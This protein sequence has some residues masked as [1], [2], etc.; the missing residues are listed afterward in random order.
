MRRVAPGVFLLRS[1]IAVQ[2][3]APHPLVGALLAA[4]GAI[5]LPPGRVALEGEK[6]SNRHPFAGHKQERLSVKRSLHL[7]LRLWCCVLL[8]GLASLLESGCSVQ[9]PL[10]LLTLLVRNDTAPDARAVVLS[11]P[12][13]RAETERAGT[14]TVPTPSAEFQDNTARA[15][16]ADSTSRDNETRL[17]S[18]RRT[19]LTTMAFARARKPLS[20]KR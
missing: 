2:P 4:P 18:R 1:V 20:L 3:V 14:E 13:P 16:I 6:V 17:S 19:T 9:F 8:I 5:F 11:Q 10:S 7:S 12:T 15:F